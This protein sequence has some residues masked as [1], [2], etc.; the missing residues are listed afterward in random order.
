MFTPGYWEQKDGPAYFKESYGGGSYYISLNLNDPSGLSSDASLNAAKQDFVKRLRAYQTAFQGGTFV[1]ELKQTLSMLRSPMR[2]LREMSGQYLHVLKKRRDLCPA[3][4]WHDNWREVLSQSWL[5]YAFGIKP[6]IGDIQDAAEL[7]NRVIHGRRSLKR[8]HGKGGAEDA[9]VTQTTYPMSAYGPAYE[10]CTL[11][12]GW[13]CMDKITAWVR[14]SSEAEG[15]NWATQAGFDPSN[16][17]PTAWELLPWSFLADYFTNLG[18]VISAS[19]VCTRGVAF[20]E[21]GTYKAHYRKCLGQ[22]AYVSFGRLA[23]YTPTR[24]EI[25]RFTK[26]RGRYNGSVVPDF[27]FEIPGFGTKWL[28]MAAL[29]EQHI[30]L[31]PYNRHPRA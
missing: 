12:E 3:V 29:W 7:L 14:D 20:A 26:A 2:S 25:E 22:K 16:W 24:V 8:I 9:T 27:R 17:A 18:D 23:N 13:R 19:T 31:T 10:R 11:K 4:K 30:A 6:L 28:N 1:G 15:L 5:E 21:R